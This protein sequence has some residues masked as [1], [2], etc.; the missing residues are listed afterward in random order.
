MTL[1]TQSSFGWLDADPERRRQILEVLDSF[2]DKTTVDDLGIG[3]IR[4]ALADTMFPGTSVLHTRLR[5]VLLVAWALRQAGEKSTVDQMWAELRRYEW[6]TLASLQAGG[7]D[8][9]V[10]GSRAQ[11]TLQRMPSS[12]YSSALRS[13]GIRKS[14]TIG[15][16]FQLCHLRSRQADLW[17][18]ELGSQNQYGT[19]LDP[20]LPSEPH[21]L[22]E[23]ANFALRQDEGQYL[24]ERIR[25]SHPGSLFAW[26]ADHEPLDLS[27]VQAPWEL[28]AHTA[29]P[30]N[31]HQLVETARGVSFTI[32]GASLLYNQ[33]LAEKSQDEERVQE[34]KRRLTEWFNSQEAQDPLPSFRPADLLRVFPE[35]TVRRVKSSREFLHEW[36]D[37]LRSAVSAEDL[38]RDAGV[39]HLISRREHRM[40][41]KRARLYN[42]AALDQWSG[43]S[44]TGRLT[45]R[46]PVVRQHLADLYAAEVPS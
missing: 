45:F 27:T 1:V 4:D 37:H 2:A 11:R 38:C 19:G 32:H 14:S 36:T 23:E 44:G 5:Y 29:L 3:T 17:L 46:W 43:A 12:I 33:A 24:R 8:Q 16:Y 42:P 13:W 15:A 39:R 22:L 20:N 41:G 25:R 35:A 9:G 10:I 21:G 40:K 26:L 31:L 34:Y 18:A 6:R 28:E 30:D 7:E